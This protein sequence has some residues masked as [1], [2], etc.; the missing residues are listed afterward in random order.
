MNETA[1]FAGPAIGGLLVA[2]I[3][4]AAV[5]LIDAGSFLIAF[6]LVAL[7][8]PA[9]PGSDVAEETTA[10]FWASGTSREIAPCSGGLSE[11]PSSRSDGRR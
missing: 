10:R 2:L 1:S 11:S 5:L 3:G 6:A 9:I 7:L 8:V 4:P